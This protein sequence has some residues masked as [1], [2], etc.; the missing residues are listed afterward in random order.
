MPDFSTVRGLFALTAELI[1]TSWNVPLYPLVPA[2]LSP[3]RAAQGAIP[4]S[5]EDCHS[6]SL[7]ISSRHLHR[8]FA[9]P[10]AP[11]LAIKGLSASCDAPDARN[12]L[13]RFFPLCFAFVLSQL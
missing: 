2:P 11:S 6:R 3:A 4:D 5:A 13:P 7:S 9:S 1:G 12:I 8:P 10:P